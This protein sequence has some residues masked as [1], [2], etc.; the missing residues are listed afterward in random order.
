MHIGTETNHFSAHFCVLCSFHKEANAM[1]EMIERYMM[2]IDAQ[3]QILDDYERRQIRMAR[4][5]E[6]CSAWRG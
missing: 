2:L 4:L 6:G 5:N 1:I 3:Q